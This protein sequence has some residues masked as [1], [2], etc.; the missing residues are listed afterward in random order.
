[1][2]ST[3]V[4]QTIVK[5]VDMIE[6]GKRLKRERIRHHWTRK[7]IGYLL[8]ENDY[9]IS[10]WEY[11]K[12]LPTNVNLKKLATLYHVSEVYILFGVEKYSQKSFITQ[13]KYYIAKKKFSINELSKKAAIT[14]STIRNYLNGERDPNLTILVKLSTTLNIKPSQLLVE[15]QHL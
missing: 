13:L 6:M 2:S 3:Y 9:L 1:M 8:N 11:G 7:E 4:V 5:Q 10:K 12:A 15:H 14:D